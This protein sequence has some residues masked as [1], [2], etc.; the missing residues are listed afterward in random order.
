MVAALAVDGP[1]AKVASQRLVA[2]GPRALLALAR[3]FPGVLAHHPFEGAQSPSLIEAQ[4]ASPYFAT[5]QKLGADAAAPILVGE[6]DHDDRLHRFGAVVGLSIIDVPAALPRLAQRA[7]DAEQ[8]LAGLA[9][10][11]LARQSASPGF[12]AILTRLRDLCRRGDDFQRLRAVRAVAALRDGGALPV[13]IDLMG[14]RPRDVADEARTAL[15]EITCQD[16]GTAERR[17][18]AW[19]ADRGHEPRRTWLL[20]A[21]AHKDI[22]LRKAAADELREDGVAL[23]DYRPDAPLRDREAAIVAVTKAQSQLQPPIPATTTTTT[24]T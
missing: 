5:L 10:D 6:L 16:F 4:A 12:Q 15:V 9:V 8:R 19:F 18:R 3:A 7:F 11:V 23:F 24:T 20:A 1:A 14:S 17:W 21:L 22:A 2:A 13:L